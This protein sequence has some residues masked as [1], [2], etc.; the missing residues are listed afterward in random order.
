[1]T[2]RV[3]TYAGYKGDEKPVLFELDG[4]RFE[5]TRIVDQWYGP[6]HAYFRVLADD[7]NTYV[8]RHQLH[9]PAGEEWALASYRRG[10]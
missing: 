10:E 9:E 2:V 7:G 4:K 1:M 6:D 8:L 3:E 5:V